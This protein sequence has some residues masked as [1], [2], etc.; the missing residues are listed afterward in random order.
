[1]RVVLIEGGEV[2]VRSMGNLVRRVGVGAVSS[3]VAAEWSG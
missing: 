1:M 2:V 3:V